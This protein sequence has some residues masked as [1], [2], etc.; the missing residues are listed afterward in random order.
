[1]ATTVGL[2]G[3]G[4][5]GG[6]LLTQLLAQGH[7][8]QAFDIS[9]DALKAAQAKGVIPVASPQ[10]AAKG[11]KFIHLFTAT[12]AQVESTLTGP[13]GVFSVATPGTMV[14]IHSTIFPATTHRVAAQAPKGVEVIDAPMTSKPPVLEE[15]GR[16]HV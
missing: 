12:D 10:E 11:A 6:A 8:V 1:M 15:I 3:V 2:I 7:R 5:M 14:L 4:K 13:D 16:A 9:A